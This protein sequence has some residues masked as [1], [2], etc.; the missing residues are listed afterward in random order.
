MLGKRAATGSC[1][2]SDWEVGSLRVQTSQPLMI[3]CNSCTQ[4]PSWPGGTGSA[5]LTCLLS[6]K[7]SKAARLFLESFEMV[8]TVFKTTVVNAFFTGIFFSCS[9]FFCNAI[10]ALTNVPVY[11]SEACL[12]M[13]GTSLNLIRL[14]GS[15]CLP[16]RL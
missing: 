2:G 10:D 3:K 12:S 11:T 15:P 5:S 6:G 16:T 8:Y 4:S 13:S 7:A 14:H 1:D 9:G